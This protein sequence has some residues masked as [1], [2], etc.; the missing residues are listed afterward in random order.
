MYALDTVNEAISS[1]KKISFVYNS[2]GTDFK[3]HPRRK[4]PYIVNPYQMVANNG[5]YY[6]IGNYDKYDDIAHFRLDKMTDVRILDAK[7]KLQKEIKDF[8]NGYNMPKHMAEHIYMF[9]CPSVRVKLLA[10]ADMMNELIDWLGKDFKIRNTEVEGQIE[11]SM[12]FWALQYGPYV[13]VIEPESLRKR[14]K[15]SIAGTVE[16]YN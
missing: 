10:P 12:F 2:Y 15:D 5:K 9:S 16:K 1:K 6:L 3:S 14:I 13:E 4:E 11:D 7:V 8:A